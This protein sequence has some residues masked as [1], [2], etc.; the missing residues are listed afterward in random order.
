MMQWSQV[1]KHYPQQWLLVEALQ[2]HSTDDK[3]ILD[4]LAVLGFYSDS[5]VAMQAY[6]Q[7]HHQSPQ[8]ELYVCHTT[9]KDLEITER[10]WLGVRGI[11]S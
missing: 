11:A 9:H 4:D 7:F 3:R 2:A 10:R 5:M 8:R 1:R 6:Q